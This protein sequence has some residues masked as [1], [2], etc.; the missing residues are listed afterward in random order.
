MIKRWNVRNIF[1]KLVLLLLLVSVLDFA[2]RNGKDTLH[3]EIWKSCVLDWL[4]QAVCNTWIPAFSFAEKDMEQEDLLNTVLQHQF[5]VFAYEK[6]TKAVQKESGNM[7]QRLINN[8]KQSVEQEIVVEEGKIN[9]LLAENQTGTG[10]TGTQEVG[11]EREMFRPE[12]W[13]SDFQKAS[14]KQQEYSWNYY[15]EFHALVR[16]FYAVDATTEADSDLLNLDELRGR[17]MTIRKNPE[18]PQILIYHT[19]SQE[20]FADSVE[21]DDSTTIM[22]AGELLARILREEYGYY[23]IHH[24]GKFDVESRD[25][26]YSNS[27]PAIEQ[28][29]QEYPTI[30]V[31]IDLHRDEMLEGRKLVMDLNGRPTAR[32]MFFNGISHTKEQGDITYLENPYIK[33]NLA[34]SFQMQVAANEYYPG[35]AR[36]IYLKGY[37]YNM[38][39]CPRSLLIELGAQ[40]NTVEEIKNACDP[41]AHILDLVLSG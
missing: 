40:T 38:H 17:D 27:L 29:L 16:E 5:P 32:L 28:I 18:V 3:G 23:V 14:E 15:Q 36:R 7:V 25:Y 41:I 22:G 39:L 34:F 12:K 20:G 4:E 9:L 35:L 33:D 30:E 24:T 1:H 11:T 13:S 31:V 2:G 37:R 10:G 19:H 6:E 8:E 21:G 26:A